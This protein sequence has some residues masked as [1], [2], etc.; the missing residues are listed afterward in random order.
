MKILPLGGGDEIGASCYMVSSK[1]THFLLDVGLRPRP[2]QNTPLFPKIYEFIESWQDIK[3]IF[4]SHAHL[5]HIGALPKAYQNNPNLKIFVPKH[6]LP[7]LEIQ[8]LESLTIRDSEDI[9]CFKEDY[10]EVQYSKTLVQETLDA[11]IEVPFFFR[12]KIPKSNVYFEF[13][14]AGHILGSASIYFSTSEGTLLYTGDICNYHRESIPDLDYRKEMK[15]DYLLS[16]S[17]YLNSENTITPQEGF[18]AL[19]SNVVEIVSE[20]GIVLIPSFSL[21]KAQEL[22]SMFCLKNQKTN[23]PVPIFLDGLVKKITKVYEDSLGLSSFHVLETKYCHEM[24]RLPPNPE[25]FVEESFKHLGSV[26]ISSSGM[27]L[28]GSKSAFWAQALASDSRNAIFFAGYLD[29]NSPGKALMNFQSKNGT[30]IINGEKTEVT[31]TV[32]KFYIGTHAHMAGI[33]KIISLTSPKDVLFVHG[34]CSIKKIQELEEKMISKY[35]KP[36]KFDKG[37]NFKVYEYIG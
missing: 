28:E 33:E 7:L 8:L 36:F 9:K 31:C 4:I 25:K 13:W 24:R 1:Y 20:G 32:D 29:E 2:F 3:A 12:R 27:L 16:E 11:V 19:F 22:A 26:I 5:D 21:G 35:N 6:C 30:V 34:N 15:V 17:T 23:R 37:I 18:E 10:D 14:P